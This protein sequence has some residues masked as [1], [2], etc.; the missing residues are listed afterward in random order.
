MNNMISSKNVLIIS[1]LL[2]F[3]NQIN[4]QI[5]H[6]KYLRKNKNPESFTYGDS[7]MYARGIC[8]VNSKVFIGNSNGDLYYINTI[9]EKKSIVFTQKDFS[10][11][12]DVEFSDN[13]LMAIQ[14]GETGKL[15]RISLDGSMKMVKN[16]EWDSLFIDAIDFKGNVGLMLAD[17]TNGK[18]NLFHTKDGGKNWTRCENSPAAK[19]DE[20]AF[21]ASGTNVQVLNDSTYV[22]V[23][24]GMTSRFFK[25]TNS[26]KSW[27]EVIVP[28]YPGLTSG[29]YS[30]C[31]ANDTSGVIVGGDYKDVG[32]R[33]NTAYYTTDGGETWMNSLET[34]NGYRSCAYYTQGIYYAC[35]SNGIDYSLDGGINWFPFAEGAYFTMTSIG[36]RLIATTKFGTVHI[37]PL[38]EE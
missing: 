38:V 22:F 21:A 5:G 31:F 12:R 36:N 8:A 16:K 13:H 33:N 17:P 19:K 34:P 37:F 30:M 14:S 24:G 9:L 2:I 32:I 23:S 26:G 18:F 11:M 3:S 6:K 25:S 35:G 29:A 27:K 10:E 1:V 7:S 4:A 28:F 20:A 15:V